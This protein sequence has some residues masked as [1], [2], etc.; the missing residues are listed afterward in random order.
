MGRLPKRRFVFLDTKLSGDDLL[1]IDF[2]QIAN[3]DI[4]EVGVGDAGLLFRPLLGGDSLVGGVGEIAVDGA[5]VGEEGLAS[6]GDEVQ[7]SAKQELPEKGVFVG[8]SVE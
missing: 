8:G 4:A 2:Q 7:Q 3:L 5:A 1:G 6:C